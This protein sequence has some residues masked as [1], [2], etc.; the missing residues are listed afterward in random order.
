MLSE[1][2]LLPLSCGDLMLVVVPCGAASHST[3]MLTSSLSLE[4]L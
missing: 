1:I 3:A 4:E 2:F